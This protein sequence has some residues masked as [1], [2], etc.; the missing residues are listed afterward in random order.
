MIV[1]VAPAKDHIL[2]IAGN[3]AWPSQMEVFV[4][5]RSVGK[6]DLLAGDHQYDVT[7]PAKIVGAAQVAMVTLQYSP[8]RVPNIETQGRTP[9]RECAIWRSIGCRYG[10][11]ISGR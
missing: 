10:P 3:A 9:M 11:P 6:V 5:G 2:T 7:V 1:P 8:P 4:N